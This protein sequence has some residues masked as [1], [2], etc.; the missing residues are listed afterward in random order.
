MSDTF[1]SPTMPASSRSQV[2]VGY[3]DYFRAR[4]VDKVG[5]LGGHDQRSS[6]LQS[7]WT[8]LELVKSAWNS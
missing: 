6:R 4:I 3:L 7:G 8:P 1:P 2:F 5:Q